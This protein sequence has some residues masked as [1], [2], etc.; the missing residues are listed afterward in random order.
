MTTFNH[1]SAF[2]WIWL[3]GAIEPIVAGKLEKNDKWHDFYYGQSYL[4]DSKAISLFDNELPLLKSRR[5][6]SRSDIHYCIRDSLPDAWGQRVLQ[7]YYSHPISVLDT[8]LLSSSDR[9][10]ALHF[11]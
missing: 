10:G 8:L 3:P 7:H 6:T 5:F 11:Q 2:V 4:S 1:D 9:I